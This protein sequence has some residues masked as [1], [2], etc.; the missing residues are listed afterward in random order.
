MAKTKVS[1]AYLLAHAESFGL[2][3]VDSVSA[4]HVK[5]NW[6]PSNSPNTAQPTACKLRSEDRERR[7]DEKNAGCPEAA[8]AE[9][10]GSCLRVP[11]QMSEKAGPLA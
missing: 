11:S 2:H 7:E 1:P 4:S 5:Y 8:S 3:L 6:L 9:S 10:E